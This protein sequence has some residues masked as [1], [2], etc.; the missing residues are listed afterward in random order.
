MSVRKNQFGGVRGTS[1]EHHLLQTWEEILV[2]LEDDRAC[3][4]L[5]LI[6]FSKGFSRISHQHCLEAFADHGASLPVLALLAAF[7]QGRTMT[8]RVNKCF[9]PTLPVNGGC[10]QGACWGF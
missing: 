8:V 9:L 2:C 3:S 1:T 10:P 4:V 7:L 6:D 5:T